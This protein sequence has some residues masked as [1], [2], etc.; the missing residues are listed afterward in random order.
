[1]HG[2]IKKGSAKLFMTVRQPRINSRGKIS[3]HH[4]LLFNFQGK[5]AQNLTNFKTSFLGVA[6]DITEH[7]KNSC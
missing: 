2:Q 3:T 7:R 5:K 4:H 6:I 1:M